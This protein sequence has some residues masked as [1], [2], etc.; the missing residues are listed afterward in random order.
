MRNMDSTVL[1]NMG[2]VVVVLVFFWG[3]Y[4][5]VCVCGR[6]G[7]RE[8]YKPNQQMDGRE[9]QLICMVLFRFAPKS[10]L[11]W[12]TERAVPEPSAHD[13][14]QVHLL[15]QPHDP[16]IHVRLGPGLRGL[17]GHDWP[18]IPHP[19]PPRQGH[20]PRRQ[21]CILGNR[22]KGNPQLPWHSN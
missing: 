7:E 10:V 3:G 15:L 16:G 5:C 4:M 14:V 19:L 17:S 22:L 20:R 9:Q 12:C 13:G 21:R 18:S 8:R 6:E 11:P 2:W 1:L